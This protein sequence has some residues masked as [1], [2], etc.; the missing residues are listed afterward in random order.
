MPVCSDFTTWY[1]EISFLRNFEQNFRF[2]TELIA[3]YTE[4]G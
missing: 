2:L 3:C 4:L 1:D